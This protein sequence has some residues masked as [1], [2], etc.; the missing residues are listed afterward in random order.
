MS[1]VIQ[2]NVLGFQVAMHPSTNYFQRGYPS[3]SDDLDSPVNHVEAMQMFQSAQQFGG[4][5]PT[6]QLVELAL[7]LQMMEQ[8]SPIDESQDQ[9]QL[10]R[11][12]E[13]KLEGYDERIVDLGEYGPFSQ[14][15]GDFGSSDNV[16]FSNRLEGVDSEGVSFTN[17]H[18]LGIVIQ[19]LSVIEPSIRQ[20]RAGRKRAGPTFPKLPLP[21]TL[22]NSNES[23]D[24]CWF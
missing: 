16:R 24:R 13:G 7:P 2:Q 8:L 23:M 11:G 22:S 18:D 20:L 14:G 17:L 3:L 1:G 19:M 5:E 6:P 4:I 15:M 21:M 10:F 9:I 12:L